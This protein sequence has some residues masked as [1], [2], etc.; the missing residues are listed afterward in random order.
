[1]TSIENA[2]HELRIALPDYGLIWD[3]VTLGDDWPKT[4]EALI[5]EH[6]S[7][8]IADALEAQTG[9]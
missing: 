5:A 7:A 9:R 1:M 6:M 4:V 8:A 2:A 3:G